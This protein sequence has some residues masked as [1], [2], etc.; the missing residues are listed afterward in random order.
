MGNQ[1]QINT[2][3]ERVKLLILFGIY[4]LYKLYITFLTGRRKEEED[5]YIYNMGFCV[6]VYQF[7][8]DHFLTGGDLSVWKI[9]N[10]ESHK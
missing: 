7:V 6:F 9:N 5:I 3:F 4:E 8:S 2:Q 10:L 1:I